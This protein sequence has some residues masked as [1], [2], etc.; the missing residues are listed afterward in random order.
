MGDKSSPL[1][2]LTIH[3]SGGDPEEDKEA[4]GILAEYKEFTTLFSDAEI[5]REDRESWVSKSKVHIWN[6]D[7]VMKYKRFGASPSSFY[8]VCDLS[9]FKDEESNLYAGSNLAACEIMP[10]FGISSMIA[11]D[12]LENWLKVW[13]DVTRMRPDRVKAI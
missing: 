6:Q 1:H 3:G 5:P 13:V 12:W 9:T 7:E 4:L 8:G 11:K 10:G 2:T